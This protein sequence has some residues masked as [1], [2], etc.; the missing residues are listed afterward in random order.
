MIVVELSDAEAQLLLKIAEQLW[1]T[2]DA[3]PR[4]LTDSQEKDYQA[5]GGAI[6]IILGAMVRKAN[7]D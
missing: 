3:K 6:S 5:A 4:P 2:L 1:A 7:A